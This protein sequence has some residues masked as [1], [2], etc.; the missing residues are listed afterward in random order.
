MANTPNITEA[1]IMEEVIAPRK[2]GLNPEAARSFLEMTFK[3]DAT[4][5]IRQLL[6]KNNRG[7]IT[8]GERA[9]LDK[10]LRVGQF[11]DLL[12]AKAQLSLRDAGD[13]Q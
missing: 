5:Q 6:L 3:R 9:L 7:T 1:D 11:L 12:R 4:K 13:S 10:Y 8:A 2:S